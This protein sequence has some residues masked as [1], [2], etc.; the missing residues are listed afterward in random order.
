VCF[1]N[2]LFEFSEGRQTM[3]QCPPQGD[4]GEMQ[5]NYH[6]VTLAPFAITGRPEAAK[7]DL[8]GA[9]PEKKMFEAGKLL[10][11]IEFLPR[12][13]IYLATN[14]IDIKNAF[15]L[16]ETVGF[17]T[18]IFDMIIPARVLAER[19]QAN[20]AAVGTKTPEVVEQEFS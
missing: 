20:E 4:A 11:G 6:R 15:S 8:T 2:L 7:K 10:R 19:G 13:G 16:V 17:Q 3:R 12:A 14:A 9:L 18:E 1:L 5:A